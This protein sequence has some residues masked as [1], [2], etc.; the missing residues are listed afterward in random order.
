[1]CFFGFLRAGEVVTPADSSFD[2]SI[3]LTAADVSV[4]CHSSP[5]YLAARIKA[6]KTELLR[7]GVT[8]YLGRTTYCICPD[9][10]VLSYLVKR[11]RTPHSW[12]KFIDGRYLTRD[13]FVKAVRDAIALS[14][15]DASK[16]AGHSLRIGAT[17]TAAS[18]GVQDSLIRTMGWW[19]CS[20]YT[21]YIRTP[22]DKI[23]KVATMLV[24]PRTP[25]V[26]RN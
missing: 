8:I 26:A 14:G 11:G 17:T 23:S 9:A 18:S 22:R 24:G 16:Y 20:V 1:M 7:Q 12:F 2:P 3:H 5:S 25:V 19:E 10:T 21:L 6:S 15:I 4:N 13:R